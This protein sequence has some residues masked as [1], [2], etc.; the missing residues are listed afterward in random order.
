MITSAAGR[1]LGTER[2][3]RADRNDCSPRYVA[4]H[5][6]SFN[7]SV[8]LR[9]CIAA[10]LRL[11]EGESLLSGAELHIHVLSAVLI[12]LSVIA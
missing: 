2:A 1:G 6:Q 7:N 4:R 11:M 9:A 3:H 12:D 5:C 8:A 10:L